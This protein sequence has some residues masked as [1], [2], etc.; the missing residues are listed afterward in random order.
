MKKLLVAGV[1]L[2]GIVI[3]SGCKSDCDKALDNMVS[4]M[5]KSTNLPAEMKKKMLEEAKSDKGKKEFM[6]K[7]KAKPETGKC[8]ANAK[9]E[10]AMGAC[11]M[12]AEAGDAG[13]KAEEAAKQAEEA[14]KAAQD[15][16]NKALEEGKKAADEAVKAADEAVK[17]AEGAAAGAAEAAKPAE[18]GAAAP[19][20]EGGA[21]PAP[22]PAPEGGAAPA[23]APAPEGGAA[24]APQ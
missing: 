11:I 4:I 5:E 17:A 22:A 20:P 24:P 18:G 16:A 10:A 14:V 23:P 19:A 15:E 1:A 12:A 7:C 21:A 3:S 9:D 8:L 2:A 13:K 6:D